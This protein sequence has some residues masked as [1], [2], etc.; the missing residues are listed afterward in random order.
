MTELETRSTE[1]HLRGSSGCVNEWEYMNA[2]KDCQCDP[3]NQSQQLAIRQEEI[4]EAMI[5]ESNKQEM[6]QSEEYDLER[7][8]CQN[9]NKCTESSYNQCPA[10]CKNWVRY[11][12]AY[13]P[14]EFLSP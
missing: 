3:G 7:S 2:L 13:Y 11:R 9:P 8:R 12:F 6:E 1:S 4:W 10:D 5:A 14:D